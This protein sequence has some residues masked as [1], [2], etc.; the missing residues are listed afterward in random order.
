MSG[1]R[2]PTE[3]AYHLSGIREIVRL[4]RWRISVPLATVSWIDFSNALIRSSSLGPPVGISAEFA[5]SVGFAEL[6]SLI[7]AP[8]HVKNHNALPNE[9]VPNAK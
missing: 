3:A 7:T 8:Q 5:V 4:L 2:P 6:V 1:E 9:F